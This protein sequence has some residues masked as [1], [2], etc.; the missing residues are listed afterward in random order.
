MALLLQVQGRAK[1]ARAGSIEVQTATTVTHLV[2]RGRPVPP[3]TTY[4]AHPPRLRERAN[5]LEHVETINTAVVEDL[6]MGVAIIVRLVNGNL[7][8]TTPLPAVHARQS[9]AP[10]AASSAQCAVK[11][12][13]LFIHGGM[14]R[15]PGRSTPIQTQYAVGKQFTNQNVEL[16][17]L[18][19]IMNMTLIGLRKLVLALAMG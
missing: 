19:P 18:V 4:T 1:L 7:A 6:A 17:G 2:Y 11:A 8:V 15:L 13:V 16:L 12:V 14:I 10:A 9:Q 3:V 5:E